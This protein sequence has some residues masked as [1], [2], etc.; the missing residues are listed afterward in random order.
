MTSLERGRKATTAPGGCGSLDARFGVAA[1]AIHT[2]VA[3]V[4]LRPRS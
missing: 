3:V 2:D 1:L 4:S